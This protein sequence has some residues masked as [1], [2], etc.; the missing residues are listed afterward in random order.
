MYLGVVASPSISTIA[1]M[2]SS[3]LFN[4][5]LISPEV[6]VTVLAPTTRPLTSMNRSHPVSGIDDST[7]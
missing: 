1:R 3:G 7:S 5:V 6:I 4:A 2:K